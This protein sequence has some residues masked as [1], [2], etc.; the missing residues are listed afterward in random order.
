[1]GSSMGP[2]LHHGRLSSLLFSPW[3]FASLL[4]FFAFTVRFHFF[5]FF[6]CLTLLLFLENIVPAAHLPHSLKTSY[7]LLPQA[8]RLAP[9][10]AVRKKS[11]ATTYLVAVA[12][13]SFLSVL[14]LLKRSSPCLFCL[15]SPR[16]SET[17]FPHKHTHHNFVPLFFTI[18]EQ[19]ILSRRSPCILHLALLF[20][21][22][23]IRHSVLVVSS[24]IYSDSRTGEH[25]RKGENDI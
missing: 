25:T 2:G 17:H 7:P 23:C 5:Y 11:C 24:R 9:S 10:L 20:S 13:S 6:T 15:H 21:R 12:P 3:P 22:L 4:P 8:A 18:T 19:A 16:L 14:A 1:M